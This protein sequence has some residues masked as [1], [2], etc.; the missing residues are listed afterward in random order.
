MKISVEFPRCPMVRFAIKFLVSSLWPI[1]VRWAQVQHRVYSCEVKTTYYFIFKACQKQPEKHICPEGLTKKWK[2]HCLPRSRDI[3]EWNANALNLRGGD[4]CGIAFVMFSSLVIGF[5]PQN[6]RRSQLLCNWTGL[7]APGQGC[8]DSSWQESFTWPI[9]SHQA[10]SSE[11]EITA[12]LFLIVYLLLRIGNTCIIQNSKSILKR[13]HISR[14][15]YSQPKPLIHLFPR[16]HIL[17]SNRYLLLFI[18]C[19]SFQKF[20]VHKQGLVPLVLAKSA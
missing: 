8:G 14:K 13:K 2:G 16:L 4:I 7:F 12:G 5:V 9:C 17:P 19:L 20:C 18:C 11:L 6:L 10:T 15:F 1:S 3:Q